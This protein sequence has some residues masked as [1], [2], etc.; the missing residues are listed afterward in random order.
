MSQNTTIPSCRTQKLS[1]RQFIRAVGAAASGFVIAS[2]QPAPAPVPPT[3]AP[4]PSS[5]PS[6]SPD[7]TLDAN[8]V[9][10][11]STASVPYVPEAQVVIGQQSD[12]ERKAVRSRMEQM[13]GD[14]WDF[15][16]I[17][18]SGAK[19]A[20]KVNL[21]G[22]V[23]AYEMEGVPAVESVVTHPEVVRALGELL[24][25]SGASQIS[26]VEA[27]YEWESF[28]LWGYE[29]IAHSLNAKLIDLNQPAP[30]ADF[31]ELPVG[32]EALVYESFTTNRILN[33]VDTFISVAKMKCHVEAGVT[34][35]MKNLV[36][37]VPYALYR[38]NTPDGART[39]FHVDSKTRLPRIIID[40]NRARP[41]HLAVI[42]GIKTVEAG[43]GTWAEGVKQVS[44]GVLIA[45]KNAL[46]TDTIATA[47]MG[48]DPSARYPNTPFNRADNYLNIAHN[49][50]MGTNMLEKI[51]LLGPSIEEVRYPFQAATGYK[52]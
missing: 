34:H 32:P 19:V 51:D 48:F 50:D 13:L 9:A 35:S 29:E 5:Q 23:N 18:P 42:D 31:G 37:M 21:T 40:L 39:S 22:G 52:S 14:L 8:G 11:T 33:E 10:A 43:E 46:A 47:V 6:V 26:I 30:Y 45:G 16:E 41:I 49:L 36:G 24:I 20:I 44:P 4:S 17:V 12:Y 7:G 27:V 38:E 2:C 3:L 1:R 15:K 25:D 28:T